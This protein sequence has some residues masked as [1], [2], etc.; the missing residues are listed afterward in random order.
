[1]KG[2][3][4]MNVI[5][6]TRLFNAEGKQDLKA[7]GFNEKQIAFCK[8]LLDKNNELAMQEAAQSQREIRQTKPSMVKGD[9]RSL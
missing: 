2:Q 5:K 8:S 9:A 4:A 6:G 1:M 7:C 3:S